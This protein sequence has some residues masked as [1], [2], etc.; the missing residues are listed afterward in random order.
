[1]FSHRKFDFYKNLCHR[2]EHMMKQLTVSSG[3]LIQG[4]LFI[5]FY[6]LL[7]F[8]FFVI[9]SN[10]LLIL[11]FETEVIQICYVA[12]LFPSLQVIGTVEFIIFIRTKLHVS[13]PHNCP[14]HFCLSFS[15][16]EH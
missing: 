12:L 10:C 14:N 9:I 1:M 15:Y 11:S 16:A 5:S 7:Y 2:M 3:M 13:T 6:L 8:T 4:E